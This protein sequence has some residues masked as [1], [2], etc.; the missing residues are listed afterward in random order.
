[1]PLL[2]Q[3]PC[4]PVLLGSLSCRPPKQPRVVENA[5][6]R[7][8]C[9][10]G[11]AVRVHEGPANRQ[12]RR[13]GGGRARGSQLGACFGSVGGPHGAGS[14]QLW[15]SSEEGDARVLADSWAG[16]LA[17]LRGAAWSCCC[18]AKAGLGEGGGRQPC[19]GRQRGCCRGSAAGPLLGA[20]GAQ[21]G[22]SSGVKTD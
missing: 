22:E 10:A 2:Q 14:A 12:K 9:A 20:A 15:R 16:A 5:M 7:W 3:H 19:A 4:L 6:L 8:L 21:L 17:V 1:M 13:G 11:P 18:S